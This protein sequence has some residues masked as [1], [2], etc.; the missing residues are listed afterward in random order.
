MVQLKAP[1]QQGQFTLTKFQF[2]MVQLKDSAGRKSS[3]ETK[4]F[5]F[6]MVQLKDVKC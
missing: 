4:K 3:S 5:Q 1:Q 6:L 2:L